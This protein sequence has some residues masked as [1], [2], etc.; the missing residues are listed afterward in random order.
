MDVTFKTEGGTFNYRAC[1]VI[2][3]G[4]KILAMKD[5]RSPYYY[6]PGGRVNLGETAQAAVL[7]E[8]REE[9]QIEAEILCPLW[10]CQNFFTEDVSR[11]NYHELCLYFL[12]DVSKT[13]LLERGGAFTL[14]ENGEEHR[15]EWL[16]FDELR[17]KYLYPLFI[18][19]EILQFPENFTLITQVE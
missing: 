5:G 12:V 14:S 15:F 7:R 8:V 4:G 13:D 11:E 1:A 16:K 10:L 6:L 2:V 18:K 19:E 9:L 3:D 17:E